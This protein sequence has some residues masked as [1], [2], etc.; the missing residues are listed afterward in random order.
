MGGKWPLLNVKSEHFHLPFSN[1]LVAIVKFHKYY[2]FSHSADIRGLDLH[3]QCFEYFDLSKHDTFF[4]ITGVGIQNKAKYQFT[5]F[6][7]F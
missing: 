5:L 7:P 1:L 3:P 4:K 2:Q 6:T